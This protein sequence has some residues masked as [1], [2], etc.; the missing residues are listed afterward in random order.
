MQKFKVWL[1]I[2]LAV[3]LAYGGSLKYG[4]SQDD[5]FFLTLSKADSL[6]DIFKF[7]SP[8]HQQGFPFFRPL[9]TQLY[10]YLFTSIFGLTK[11]PLFM[12]IFMLLVQATN[13]F[14]VYLLVSKLQKS[15]TVSLVVSLLYATAAAHFIS[16]FYIAAT[17]QLLAATFS[18][19]SLNVF[20]HKKYLKAGLW[21][22]VGLLCKETAIITP[23]IAF[24]LWQLSSPRTNPFKQIP[25]LINAFLPFIIVIISYLFLRYTAGFQIQSEYQPVIG[26]SLASTLRWYF[27]F[28]YGA[29]EELLRYGLP[30]MFINFSRFIFDFG[31]T[32]LLI[33]ILALLTSIFSLAISITGI[34]T[35]KFLTRFKTVIYMFWWVVGISLVV[36]Y[37]DHR[38]PHYLDLA[39]IPLLLIVIEVS[40][41]YF[42][43]V[44]AIIM[45]TT[46]LFAISIST[47]AHWT[48]GRALMVENAS[49]VLD[50]VEICKHDQIVFVG[51]G[52]EPRELSYSL[53]LA[54]GPRVFCNNLE[55][56]VYYSGLDS[57]IPDSAY[58]IDITKVFK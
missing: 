7:F 29:P 14:L 16:L 37:P 13:G 57:N 52:L 26:F 28:G 11:A 15:R 17:Q 18:L 8:W 22:L 25:K 53:S 51:P 45:L 21:L 12:H 55:L 1:L 34:I 41:G 31:F 23:I 30:R 48:T 58:Q 46:S 39:L 49:Q 43:Y 32:A 20:L 4:F 35:N 3:V 10:Y 5:F 27:L 19:L 24:L 44:I 33:S 38:Y 6:S 50:W 42:R 54:N 36:W 40:R 56:E 9:G 47:K 2:L